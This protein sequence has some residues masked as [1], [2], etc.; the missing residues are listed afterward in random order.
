MRFDSNEAYI[1]FEQ[2]LSGVSFNRFIDYLNHF[3]KCYKK[4]KEIQDNTVIDSYAVVIEN[5]ED[6]LE[7]VQ[8]ITSA[9]LFTN[10]KVVGSGF[11]NLMEIDNN[12]REEV[13]ITVKA[14]RKKSLSKSNIRNT[15]L[16][17]ASGGSSV[18]R[19]RLKCKDTDEISIVLDTFNM[20]KKDEI[21]VALNDYG[22]V[23][24]EDMFEKMKEIIVG[25]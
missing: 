4:E 6:M 11:L 23:D 24:T 12:T 14:E 17:F 3:Y 9:E 5:F 16:E 20:K 13:S 7:N 18:T 22:V 1:V 2:R 10:R 21:T 15:F 25:V 8:R 19:M